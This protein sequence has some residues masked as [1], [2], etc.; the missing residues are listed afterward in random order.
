M[1]LIRNCDAVPMECSG[2]RRCIRKEKSRTWRYLHFF[3]INLFLYK[4]RVEKMLFVHIHFIHGSWTVKMWLLIGKTWI[5]FLFVDLFFLII[6]NFDRF[7]DLDKG[8]SCIFSTYARTEVSFVRGL[9]GF[10]Q[11]SVVRW[12]N[13]RKWWVDL[14]Q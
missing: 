2:F 3:V 13:L 9:L 8:S 14:R 1:T 10:Q 4:R 5:Q 12:R 6:I 7:C 11:D